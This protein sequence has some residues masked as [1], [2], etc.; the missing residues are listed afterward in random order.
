MKG[1][2]KRIKGGNTLLSYCT[3][4]GTDILLGENFP[5]AFIWGLHL[6]PFRN[7]IRAEETTV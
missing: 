7:I 5:Q 6:L 1:C 2:L 3:V 4:K